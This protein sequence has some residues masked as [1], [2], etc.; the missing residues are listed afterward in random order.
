MAE[1]QKKALIA[2][3]ALQRAELSN[4][5]QD[6]QTELSL[7][8]QVQKSVRSHPKRWLIGSALAALSLSLALR[9]KKI[10]YTHL[11]K[12]RGLIN[13]SLR[14]TLGLVRPALTTYAIKAAKDYAEKRLGP[15]P[16]NSML[17]DPS[18][19]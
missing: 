16:D 2:Q 19:K 17:G 10:I 1:A 13:R 9:R 14:L 3:L 6:L 7:S 12:R 8:R 15:L 5:R 18:Q 4:S 11:N